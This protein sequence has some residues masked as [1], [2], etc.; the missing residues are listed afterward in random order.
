MEPAQRFGISTRMKQRLFM[1]L[2]G[3]IQ[4]TVQP[5]CSNRRSAYRPIYFQGAKTAGCPSG[6]C[7]TVISSP[8][9]SSLQPE[10]QASPAAATPVP[11]PFGFNGKSDD[12]QPTDLQPV[13]PPRSS[14]DPNTNRT[15]GTPTEPE[16]DRPDSSS[17][18]REANRPRIDDKS[19]R[20]GIVPPQSPA[21]NSSNEE[22]L[23]EPILAPP[24]RTSLK[25]PKARIV[26]GQGG[27]SRKNLQTYVN[28]PDDL[29]TPPKA[30]RPWKYIVIHHSAHDS[31]SLAKIDEDHRKRLGTM[32]CGY[33]FVVGNGSETQNGTIE[34]ANRWAEQKGGQHCRDSHV[35]DINEYG[36]GICLI[37]NF[38]S[39]EPT[40]QQLEA[41]G[42]LIAYLQQ[43]Y[44]IPKGNVVTHDTVA[45]SKSVCPGKN[46]P[47]ASLL[48]QDR[49]MARMSVK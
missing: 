31:G 43:R 49:G 30:D 45:N 48:G 26:P 42:A 28:D 9:S 21:S 24:A 19:S 14:A 40:E 2:L 15:K 8:S 29:F 16:F 11:T 39:S 5:G 7:G 20:A 4:L 41:T 22:Q 36:I 18:S 33:H 34:V 1:V 44:G 17:T 32:G 10:L 12:E 6:D 46:F 38:D 13:V 37:G 27:A 47:T 3:A 35:N 25:S 23:D